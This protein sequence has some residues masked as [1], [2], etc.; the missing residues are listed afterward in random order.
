MAIAKEQIIGFLRLAEAG[1]PIK[2]IGRK[3]GFSDASFYKWRSKYGGM[4]ASEGKPLREL[5]LENGKLKRLLAEAHL[6]IHALKSVFGIKLV[7]IL[8]EPG[9]PT[10][11][12][13]IKSFNGTFRD[14][15]LEENWFES[16]EQARQ[17]I[18]TWRTDYNE[19]R[20]HSSCGRVPPATFAALN[21]H[22]TGDS[23]QHSKI[24]EGI[25]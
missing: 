15:C 24:N 19:T 20:P 2:E 4:D 11:N 3:H 22:L 17:T 8:I 16:L 23:M 12:A 13:Y 14:E 6:D 10:Q 18:A 21:R 25:S 5:E 7:I 9:S 1:M